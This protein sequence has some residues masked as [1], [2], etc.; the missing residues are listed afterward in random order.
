M[1]RSK[2]RPFALASVTVLIPLLRSFQKWLRKRH[3]NVQPIVSETPPT[4]QTG[5]PELPRVNVD[6]A[7][8]RKRELLPAGQSDCDALASP[9]RKATE[10]PIIDPREEPLD[11]HECL[12][13][14]GA[15]RDKPQITVLT[16]RPKPRSRD[17]KTCSI[18]RIRF[19][20]KPVGMHSMKRLGPLL[21]N[22]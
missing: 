1:L 7:I 8:S 13:L 22:Q 9:A 5:K 20:T 18:L 19:G 12:L 17:S 3:W 4:A 21:T 11:E 10:L 2:L 6:R 16:R 14:I 15:E